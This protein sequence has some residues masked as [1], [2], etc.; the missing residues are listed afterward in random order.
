MPSRS[1]VDGTT[2]DAQ[3]PSDIQKTGP[4]ATQED[5]RRK[6]PSNNSA[7]YAKALRI[8]PVVLED[9]T[10]EIESAL[11]DFGWGEGDM[12]KKSILDLQSDIRRDLAKLETGSWLG[13]DDHNDE[14]VVAVGRML[15]KA[16]A[17][18]EEM[19]GLLTLYNVELGVSKR[20]RHRI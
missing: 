18:C 4:L 12:N 9:R 19:D 10:T 8:D 5:R 15:D 14:R 20:S 3:N 6:R 7:K 2:E 16:I 13:N 1:Q 17:E 11:S